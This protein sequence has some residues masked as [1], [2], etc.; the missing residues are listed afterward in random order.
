MISDNTSGPRAK[1]AAP[2]VTVSRLAEPQFSGDWHDKPLVWTVQGPSSEVQNFRTK[3]WAL[4]YARL[5]RQS[6]SFDEAQRRFIA[7]ETI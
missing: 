4:A 3:A 7:L 6:N 5:R 2:S 1:R